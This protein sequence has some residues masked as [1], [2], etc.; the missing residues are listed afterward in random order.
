MA[1]PKGFLKHGRELPKRR[2]VDVR[3]SDWREVYEPSTTQQ[4]ATQAGRCMDCGVP[5]CHEGCPLGNLIPEWNDLVWRADWLQAS[6][7]LHATNN[8]PKTHAASQGA[9]HSRPVNS[10]K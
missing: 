9:G 2:P 10:G 8:F 7:R 5:F 4:L 3:I 1:D 6:E